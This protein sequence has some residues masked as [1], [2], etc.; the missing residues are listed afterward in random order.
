MRSRAQSGQAKIAKKQANPES[1]DE[2]E[3]DDSDEKP[4]ARKQSNVSAK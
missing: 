3:S 2:E 4:A 1:S